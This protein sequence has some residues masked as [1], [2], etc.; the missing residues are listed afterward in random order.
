MLTLLDIDSTRRHERFSRLFVLLVACLVHGCGGR[1]AE[2]ST[3]GSSGGTNVGGAGNGSA[4]TGGNAGTAGSVICDN[5]VYWPEL[6]DCAYVDCCYRPGDPHV[7]CKAIG[8]CTLVFAVPIA[9][10]PFYWLSL[11]GMDYEG[12]MS[13]PDGDA[14]LSADRTVLM[15][16]EALCQLWQNAGRPQ[17]ILRSVHS[18]V[19]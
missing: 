14:T 10:M 19:L 1:A 2:S 3:I 7:A 16:H 8:E 17:L 15:L 11:C 18:C 12:Y 5:T 6:P 13:T 9:D 4:T